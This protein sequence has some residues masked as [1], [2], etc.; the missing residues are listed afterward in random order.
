MSGYV[1]E[2]FTHMH[3]SVWIS[4]PLLI[5]RMCFRLS[6]DM[7]HNLTELQQQQIAKE[8]NCESFT[9]YFFLHMSDYKMSLTQINFRL[10][11]GR[12][13]HLRWFKFVRISVNVS[14]NILI[15]I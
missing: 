15:F 4:Q 1:Q 6:A 8:F 9:L 12:I 2:W 5:H 13:W 3:G 7:D 11:C 10:K 14:M